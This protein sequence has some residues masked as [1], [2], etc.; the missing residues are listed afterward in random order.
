MQHTAFGRTLDSLDV[1]VVEDSRPMQTIFRSVL[2]ACG[3]ARLRVYDRAEQALKDMLVEPPQVLITDWRMDPMSGFRLVR[4]IRHKDLAPLCFTPAI[5]VTGHATRDLVDRAFRIG[6]HQIMVK[7]LAPAALHKRLLCLL[8][9]PRAFAL[10]GDRYV[11]GGV[12]RIL[13]E[14]RERSSLHERLRSMADPAARPEPQSEADDAVPVPVAAQ[15][16]PR[17]AEVGTEIDRS[18]WGG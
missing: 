8:S 3:V 11:I 1:V 12:D 7:P 2:S 5:M 15:L 6:V 9:D 4:I 13:D 16:P 14:R 18:V 10:K 17:L